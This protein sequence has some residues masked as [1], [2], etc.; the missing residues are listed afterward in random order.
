MHAYVENK[1]TKEQEKAKGSSTRI[2]SYGPLGYHIVSPA[3]S[4]VLNAGTNARYA[5]I[6]PLSTNESPLVT[7]RSRMAR[8][9][10]APSRAV[11]H[12]TSSRTPQRNVE[13]S[14]EYRSSP[15]LP[16]SKKLKTTAKVVDN[17][18]VRVA[19]DKLGT[20]LR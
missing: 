19:G 8:L 3:Y 12:E 4:D 15:P 10:I 18:V 20:L 5:Q 16:P 1:S 9:D 14:T 13:S 7:P 17:F 2:L 11:N 6:A